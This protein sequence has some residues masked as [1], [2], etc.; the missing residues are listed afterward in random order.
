VTRKC[1]MAI[2]FKAWKAWLEGREIT[3]KYLNWTPDSAF[4]VISK[5]PA[6]E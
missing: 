5:V 2:V 3:L 1:Q 6:D 4:P